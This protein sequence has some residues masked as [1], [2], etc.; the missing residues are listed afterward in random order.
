MEATRNAER[1]NSCEELDD[2]TLVGL[3]RRGEEAAVRAIIKRHNRRMFRTARAIVRDDWEAEDVVQEA[4]VRAFTHLDSFRGDSSLP[5]W[6]TRIALNEALTRLRR[7]RPTVGL[8][9]PD[10]E[11]SGVDGRILAFPSRSPDP[12]AETARRQIHRLIEHAVDGLPEHFRIVF[13]LR[14]I[15]TLSTEET[16]DQLGIKPETVKTRLHRARRLMRIAVE[17]EFAGTLS[18]A[19]PFDGLRCA[20]M[21]DRVL[22]RLQRL[23]GAD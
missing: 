9:H 10:V 13:V 20:H 15:E 11:T 18:D 7:Q 8:D 5:T 16:A 22:R 23:A 14:D 1:L 4:Y 6:L 2:D 17:R 19:F 12:E 21:A 3:A